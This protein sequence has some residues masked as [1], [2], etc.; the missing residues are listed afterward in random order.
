ME[1]AVR[2]GHAGP[3][4]G[5]AAAGAGR[6]RHHPHGLGPEDPRPRGQAV[7]PPHGRGHHQQVQL[8]Q[9]HN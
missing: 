8:R 7:R 1:P 3:G 6:G 9:C 5:G 2:G 4:G